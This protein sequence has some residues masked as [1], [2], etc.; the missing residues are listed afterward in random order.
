MYE[1]VICVSNNT[2]ESTVQIYKNQLYF[3]TLAIEM[4]IFSDTFNCVKKR[5]AWKQVLKICMRLVY[6]RLFIKRTLLG[7]I[8][9]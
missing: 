5:N 7:K 1:E 9:G 6:S 8:K 3:C 2:Q 4:E